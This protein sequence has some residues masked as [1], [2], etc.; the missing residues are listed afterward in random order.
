MSPKH[1]ERRKLVFRTLLEAQQECTELF[2][3]GYSCTGNW[4]LGQMCH[5]LRITQ[6]ASLDG[7]PRW[8]SLFAPVRPVLRWLMLKRLL[9]GDSPSGIKTAKI[10]V[11]PAN[12]ADEKELSSYVQ[13][14]E[15]FRSYQGK[16]HTHPGFGRFSHSE[17]GQF[18][19]CHAAHHLSFLLPKATE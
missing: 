2:A 6:D 8:M 7:Y 4:T 16:L 17:F 12:I 5:H 18:H 15:R 14:I 13:S 10:F 3:S 1:P 11:P 9:S 19:A